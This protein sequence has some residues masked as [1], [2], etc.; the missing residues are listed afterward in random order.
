MVELAENKIDP[1]EAEW[2]CDRTARL[3]QC[4]EDLCGSGG[5]WECT[6][7]GKSE[8]LGRPEGENLA[9]ERRELLRIR[10]N[11]NFGDAVLWE[12]GIHIEHFRDRNLVEWGVPNGIG[13]FGVA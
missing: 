1:E 11:Y 5:G 12:C 2:V 9:L 13:I 6:M 4:S 3:I 10:S 7:Q 8:T